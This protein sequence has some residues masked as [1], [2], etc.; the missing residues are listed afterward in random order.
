[1]VGDGYEDEGDDVV[2]HHD[3]EVLAT[4]LP[5]NQ[6]ADVAGVKPH[7]QAVQ[8]SKPRPGATSQ[9]SDLNESAPDTPM[10]LA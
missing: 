9:K 1:M 10:L 7:F 8:P 5:E 4:G 6:H 3:P 2:H